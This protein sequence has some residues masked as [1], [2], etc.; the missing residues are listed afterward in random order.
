LKAA[1]NFGRS[2]SEDIDSKIANVLE[3]HLRV[4]VG[5]IDMDTI[6]S[7]TR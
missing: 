6:L 7:K 5:Q 1:E 2:K 4:V 3:G